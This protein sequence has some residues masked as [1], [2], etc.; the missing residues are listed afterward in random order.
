MQA[1]ASNFSG[2]VSFSCP[3]TTFQSKVVQWSS[4]LN[5]GKVFKPGSFQITWLNANVLEVF[6]A[7]I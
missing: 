7:E 5:F 6:I 1:S 2:S 3:F 4:I